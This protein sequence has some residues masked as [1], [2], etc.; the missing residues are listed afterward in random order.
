M[1]NTLLISFLLIVLLTQATP[2]DSVYM[3]SYFKGNGQDGLHLAYS[4][5]GLVW[6]ALKEDRSFLKPELSS[7]KLMRDPCIIQGGDG[8]FHMVW[9]VSWTQRG[10]GYSS[11]KDLVNWSEQVYIPVMEH[12]PKARN[13]WAPEIIYDTENEEYMIYWATTIEGLFPETQIEEDDRYNHRM[14]Y[15]KTKDF[16]EFS[17]TKLLYD[18]GFNSIDASIVWSGKEWLM[19]IKDETRVPAAKNI[20][21][22]RSKKLDGPYSPANGAITGTYWAEGP[23][24]IKIDGEWVV[25]FDKY[26][27]KKYGAIKSK[28]LTHWEDI[29]DQVVMPKGIRHGTVFK[30][31]KKEF[32][33]LQKLL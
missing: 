26:T 1:K 20:K 30:I 5:D 8:K 31:S 12:E 11:S 2:S 19:F 13:T 33:R 29:S 7:D 9:T 27:E 17:E 16:I 6:E 10:I 18:P 25:Y 28:D 14:Y 15:T 4:H 24:A 32:S 21:I 22:A 3:F 23:T